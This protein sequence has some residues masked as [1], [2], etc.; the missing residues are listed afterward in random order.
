MMWA[1]Y[2]QKYNVSVP[3][4]FDG[5]NTI[6]WW[7][8]KIAQDAAHWAS[9]GV[10]DCLFP[11]PLKCFGGPYPGSDGYGCFDDYDIGSKN[12][13]NFGGIPTRF[14]Y[15]EQLRRAIAVCHANGI[16]V[17]IDHVMHQRMGAP[18]ATYRYLSST[19]KTNGRFP[20]DPKCFRITDSNPDGVPVDSVPSPPDDFPFGDQLCPIN[21]IPKDYVKNNLI[22]AGDWLFTTLDADGARLDD[23]KGINIGFMKEW[24]TS[25]A[26]K[27]KWFFG[28]YASG[29]SNDLAWYEGMID[30]LMS[31][32]DFDFHYNIAQDMCEAGGS[33]FQM[34]WLPGRGFFRRNPM[35]AVTW[36]ESLDSDTNGF[37][38]IVNNKTLAYAAMLCS[39]GLPCVYIRDYLNEPSCYGLKKYIDN[40]M[41]I[42]NKLAYGPTTTRYTDA[43]VWIFERT[44]QPG[45]IC[46]LNNDFFNPEWK[47]VNVQTNFGPNVQ[48]HDYTGH[49]AND[50]WTDWQG[51]ATFAIPPGAN[52]FGYCCWSRAGVYEPAD[53]RPSR[54]TTQIFYGAPDLD[55]AP[56]TNREVIFGRIWCAANSAVSATVSIDQTGW[57]DTSSATWRIRD[58]NSTICSNVLSYGTTQSSGNGRTEEEGWH[59][60][61]ISGNELPAT[62]SSF[63]FKVTY[64]A[65]K[66]F[67]FVPPLP[68]P[69]ARRYSAQ[70]DIQ[71]EKAIEERTAALANWRHERITRQ[72]R[73]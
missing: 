15:A 61:V 32:A 71:L 57:D 29:N 24:M 54:A 26:M 22:N 55:I 65:P 47:F 18:R 1:N 51:R 12:T 14:G 40:L 8:D 72:S 10:T 33:N 66:T 31:L 48:L 34:S 41:W 43:K 36:V 63:Y 19:G 73:E 62:G 16:N 64:T 4:P 28:E 9:L 60:L 23:M 44:G 25:K 42:A 59:L 6:P 56:A 67:K 69:A 5:D 20:K 17:L 52:G 46:C 11:N 50:T 30:G 21:S 37:A 39:E 53:T 58:S 3:S 49:N 70:P 2:R 38:T 35:K 68:S 13:Q 27:G 7:Y 45:L